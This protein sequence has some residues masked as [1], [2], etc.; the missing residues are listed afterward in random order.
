MGTARFS[1]GYT[2]SLKPSMKSAHSNVSL[3]VVAGGL[4]GFVVLASGVWL[5]RFPAGGL[6]QVGR[7]ASVTFEDGSVLELTESANDLDILKK[8]RMRGWN[9]HEF[10]QIFITAD[11]GE[12]EIT[13]NRPA[14]AADGNDL[15]TG[16]HLMMAANTV[17]A[18]ENPALDSKKRQAVLAN[19]QLD[20]KDK[21][22]AGAVDGKDSVYNDLIDGKDQVFTDGK[23]AKDATQ[24]P[25]FA[26]TADQSFI[27]EERLDMILLGGGGYFG[28]LG[29]PT[30]NF[31]AAT[32]GNISAPPIG[33]AVPEPSTL[34][35]AG[36]AGA[37]GL[38]FK[39]RR[40]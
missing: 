22:I 21:V 24:Q 2:I 4:L 37:L 11:G 16:A 12:I 18:D 10:Q 31:G 14:F 15:S 8:R 25:V 40:R 7:T 39:A 29:G 26:L 13:N 19:L 34:A 3:A 35:L 6:K 23:D 20:G 27:A 17:D 33:S 5:P 1:P 32:G 30:G 9:G 36:L 28:S 38:A